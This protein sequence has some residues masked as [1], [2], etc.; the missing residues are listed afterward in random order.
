MFITHKTSRVLQIHLSISRCVPR[1]SNRVSWLTPE[2]NLNLKI[3][4]QILP[5]HLLYE[6]EKNITGFYIKAGLVTHENMTGQKVYI[7]Q[8]II[9]PSYNFRVSPPFDSDIAI[10]KLNTT[11][12]FNADVQPACLPDPSFAPDETGETAFIR[13]ADN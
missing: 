8:V 4:D 2:L 1:D 11:L 10:V 6:L 12:I 13:L 9:H 3:L 5:E 7:E